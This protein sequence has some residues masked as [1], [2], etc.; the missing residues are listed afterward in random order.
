MVEP[1][2]ALSEESIRPDLRELVGDCWLGGASSASS[3]PWRTTGFPRE[4]W[5]CIRT[6]NAIERLPR[7]QAGPR[8]GRREAQV[9]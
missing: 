7:R 9:V 8:T 2:A 5:R 6:N 4:R 1:V 3:R